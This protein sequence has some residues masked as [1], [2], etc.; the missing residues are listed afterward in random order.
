MVRRPTTKIIHPAC[1]RRVRRYPSD[2]YASYQSGQTFPNRGRKAGLADV[3]ICEPAELDCASLGYRFELTDNDQRKKNSISY[4]A[5][6]SRDDLR[7]SL[8]TDG[9]LL[10]AFVTRLVKSTTSFGSKV[11][12]SSEQSIRT[13]RVNSLQ[14]G[15]REELRID[16]VNL[17][18]G[19]GWRHG[20]GQRKNHSA[21]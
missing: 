2:S 14:T 1:T 20:A 19:G 13:Q 12:T 9:R 11:P 4:D 10:S 3:S 8:W 16:S 18:E 5:R 7:P 6:G 17:G 15:R 21:K